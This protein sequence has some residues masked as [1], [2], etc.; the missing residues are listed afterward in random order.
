MSPAASQSEPIIRL[1]TVFDIPGL[2]RVFGEVMPDSVWPRMG[3]AVAG[4]YMRH[5]IESPLE[6]MIVA[7]LDGEVVGFC[8]G[9]MRP[10]T[11]GRDLYRDRLLELITSFGRAAIR[12]PGVLEV[13][14]GRVLHGVEGRVRARLAA[15]PERVI[16]HPEL[17]DH[18]PKACFMSLYVV[19]PKARGR[20]I[21][22]LAS[23]RFIKEVEARGF[24]WAKGYCT[25]DNIASQIAQE[26]AGFEAAFREGEY[27][28]HY[29]RLSPVV[30]ATVPEALTVEIIDERGA[31]E[32][33]RDDWTRLLELTPE[34]S[35]FLSPGWVLRWWDE[36]EDRGKTL[37][38]LVLRHEGRAV[39]LFP[40]A[41]H[42]EVLRFIACERSNYCGPVFEP[43]LLPA[44]VPRWIDAVGRDGDIRSVDLTGLRARSPF[45]QRI[46]HESIPRL[47]APSQVATNTC[48]EVDLRPGWEAVIGR[49]KSKQ[50]ATW[51]RKW[52]KL[53]RFGT[54][55]FVETS[56]PQQI[57]AAM[58]EM[59]ELYAARWN[60]N[61]DKAFHPEVLETQ[62]AVA[63]ELG[64]RGAVLL[65]ML[66]LDG[67]VIAYAYGLRGGDITSSYTL[68]HDEG[69]APYSPGLLLLLRVLEAAAARGDPRYDFSLGT[70]A[71]KSLW[72]SDEQQ[73]WSVLWGPIARRTAIGRRLWDAA[74]SVPMLRELKQRGVRGILPELSARLSRREP[75]PPPRWHV[76]RI[77][78]GDLDPQ[79]LR[80]LGYIEA[81]ERLEP[82]LLARAVDRQFRGD[83]LLSLHT[84]AGELVLLWQAEGRRVPLVSGELE[85]GEIDAVYY[86]PTPSKLDAHALVRRLAPLGPVVLVTREALSAP[87]VTSLGS[88]SAQ[89]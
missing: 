45:L 89:L 28:T 43:E 63:R 33:L 67:K 41:L 69:L 81:R 49:H 74:R 15:K 22:T 13:V 54:L 50:R 52:G 34:T 51:R 47:G 68:A 82:E 88:F 40:T 46:V 73:V 58:P 32:S 25:V 37:R 59:F 87:G 2:V 4:E 44:I 60:L 62:L 79:P 29:R 7:L 80:P 16:L 86:D 20:R 19:S 24:S 1:A 11:A 3:E 36:G 6:L 55:E 18:P 57:A 35:A 53:E 14:G 72:A 66:R 71:Y 64:P 30:S 85:L 84:E 5:H 27:L 39:A 9:T 31:L 56:D 83:T 10:Q 17:K 8:M 48:P 70:A 78:R 65:S 12:D 77:E 76:H 38:A 26:R 21:A 61:V 75:P 23:E 42:E